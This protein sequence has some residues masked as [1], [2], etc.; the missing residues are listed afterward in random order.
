LKGRIV[1]MKERFVVMMFMVL[2]GAVTAS[3]QLPGKVGKD[4]N[5]KPFSLAPDLTIS[6]ITW[7]RKPHTVQ[8]TVAN[9]GQTKAAESEGGYVCQGLPPSEKGYSF[10]Y[11]AG[12]NV[13]ALMPNQKWKIVLDCGDVIIARARIDGGKKIVESNEKNNSVE[14]TGGQPEQGPLEKPGPVKKA[15]SMKK[16]GS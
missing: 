8:I 4:P 11:G 3:A 15:G 5:P 2:F 12:F 1:M 9:I 16:P 7:R 13:P 6:E 10:G 14:F